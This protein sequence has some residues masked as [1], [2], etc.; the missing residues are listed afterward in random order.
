ME[1]LLK[2]QNELLTSLDKTA[3]R[4][5]LIQVAQLYEEKRID[6][7]GDRIEEQLNDLN[8]NV[9]KLNEKSGDNL[10]SNVIKLTNALKSSTLGDSGKGINL[11]NVIPF[12]SIN[13]DRNERDP[14]DSKSIVDE[15]SGRRRYNEVQNVKD[16]LK[17]L[18]SLRGFLDKM[19]IAPRGE[20]GLLS[21]FM[22]KREN[23]KNW[24]ES[25]MRVSD[26]P[27]LKQFGGDKGKIKEYLSEQFNKKVETEESIFRNVED[28]KEQR[29][30]GMSDEQISRM[31]LFERE[32]ELTTQLAK[33][34]PSL[35]KQDNQEQVA[36]KKQTT[37]EEQKSN[38]IPLTKQPQV[39]SN[40]PTLPNEEST[41]E[42][43]RMI[44]EQTGLLKK[45]EENTS[46]LKS[47]KGM[48][49]PVAGAAAAEGG[50]S[51]LDMIP[52]K[53][54][55]KGIKNIGKGLIKGAKTVGRFALRNAGKLGAIGAVG[56]GLYE[57]YEGWSAAS[58]KEE[59]ALAE[60]DARVEAGEITPEEAEALKKQVGETA[61]VE[62]GAA[63]GKGG[64]MA[65]GGA[66]GALKGA[67]IGATIGSAV[68]IVGTVIGGAIGATVG[69]IGGSWLGGKA[70]EWV[71]EKAGQATNWVKGF[72]GGGTKDEQ[73]AKVEPEGSSV[74]IQFSEMEFAQKD[75]ENY[76]KFKE[77]RD[78]LVEKYAKEQ[79]KKFNKKEPDNNDYKVA[80]MMANK[81][82]VLK[83]RNEIEAAG[84]GKI[85]GG[86]KEVS[87]ETVDTAKESLAPAIKK[88][89]IGATGAVGAAVGAVA[90]VLTD[91]DTKEWVGDKL[92]KAKNWLFGKKEEAQLAEEAGN[93][94]PAQ[95]IATETQAAKIEPIVPETS[96]KV[97]LPVSPNTG[98]KISQQSSEVDAAKLSVSKQAASQNNI[99]NAPVVN[100]TTN[101]PTYTFKS[102]PRTQEN[103]VTR[104]L[105]KRYA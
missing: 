75:P 56:A 23:R 97:G 36:N 101:R 33:I 88:M 63:A 27:E 99:V 77:H 17:D 80:T 21:D 87:K 11:N 5:E 95:P 29:K 85:S 10:N 3:K 68:P 13:A 98:D 57:G 19:H 9:K 103:S 76:K 32:K 37:N 45:I 102:Q 82:A 72:F 26:D 71:G 94:P 60:I 58:E 2:K 43:N 44:A 64:G 1:A 7:D 50:G 69:A 83:F 67:A 66:V 74:D 78:E 105:D 6:G 59:N 31:G 46:V 8:D 22:D 100:N 42:Q 30:R 93:V 52:T 65:L 16:D 15:V 90:S 24:V 34:D 54:L 18:F 89:A 91:K 81:D 25:R 86:K 62:K 4:D 12:P 96:A 61:T 70:G 92:S 38:V 55:A 79:A 47:M 53:G 28:I 48:A 84:A 41:L 35:R 73:V 49:G 51:L 14:L 20:S 104:Y 40:I 39:N